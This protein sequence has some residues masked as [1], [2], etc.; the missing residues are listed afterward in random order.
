MITGIPDGGSLYEFTTDDGF[1]V[2][3][4]EARCRQIVVNPMALSLK[5]VFDLDP[6]TA[7]EAARQV[8]YDF[9]D[10]RIDDWCDEGDGP[11]QVPIET[12]GQV[13]NFSLSAD[14][15]FVL[16]TLNMTMYFEASTLDVRV[17]R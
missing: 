16:E 13:S 10:A 8:T 4:H 11:H 15:Y 2:S 5:I 12:R 3:L 1:H 14:R 9:A 17:S 7:D 6:E